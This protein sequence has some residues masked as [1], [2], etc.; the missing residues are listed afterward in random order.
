MGTPDHFNLVGLSRKC[1]FSGGACGES[2]PHHEWL[3]IVPH[4]YLTHSL[5]LSPPLAA[6]TP[7]A[8]R[9]S[10]SRIALSRLRFFYFTHYQPFQAESPRATDE[11]QAEERELQRRKLQ[12]EVFALSPSGFASCL[13]VCLFVLFV[14]FAVFVWLCGL[15][16]VTILS[17]C[18]KVG[19]LP[20]SSSRNEPKQGVNL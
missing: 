12:A 5:A 16:P 14:L 17:L 4:D 7:H 10:S 20:G 8:P 6:I 15:L 18:W 3:K 11:L 1:Q 2:V 9:S 13:S 19:V